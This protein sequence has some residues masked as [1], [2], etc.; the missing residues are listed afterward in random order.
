MVYQRTGAYDLMCAAHLYLIWPRLVGFEELGNTDSF[1][2]AVLETRLLS[3]GMLLVLAS[4]QLNV[5]SPGVISRSPTAKQIIYSVVSPGR[6]NGQDSDD[7]FD[8]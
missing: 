1:T 5:I 6:T 8:L 4:S 3:C 7:V 2:T